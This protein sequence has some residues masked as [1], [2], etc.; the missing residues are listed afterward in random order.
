LKS[1]EIHMGMPLFAVNALFAPLQRAVRWMGRLVALPQPQVQ[2]A[3]AE[4]TSFAHCDTRR[5]E[6]A[7]RRLRVVRVVEAAGL[8]GGGR[9]VISG[10]MADVCAELERLAALEAAAG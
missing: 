1:K 7:P 3:G 9:M 5:T 6:A 2:A 10:R 4:P 8:A